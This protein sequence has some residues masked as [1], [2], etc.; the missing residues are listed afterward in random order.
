MFTCLENN[1]QGKT[2]RMIVWLLLAIAFFIP[3][4]PWVGTILVGILALMIVVQSVREKKWAL[5][6]S[7]VGGWIWGLVICSALSITVSPIPFFSAY[8]WLYG[9]ASYV[10]V[11]YATMTYMTA[12]EDRKKLLTVVI[13]SAILVCLYG[14]VQ[15]AHETAMSAAWVDASEFPL[16]KRRLYSTLQNPNLMGAYLLE[17]LSMAGP[18]AICY[19]RLKTPYL[20]WIIAGFFLLC[21]VFTYSRGIWI[22][23]ACMVLYWGLVLNRKLLLSLLA[24][25]AVLFFYHGGVA[26]R[27]WSLFA[28]ADTSVSLRYAIWD[29]TTYMIEEFPLLGIGWGA[30]WQV[31]P[32][33]NYF[34]QDT[35]TII[36]H[37]HNMYLH[38]AAE[39][40]IPGCICFLMVLILHAWKAY[41]LPV[42]DKTTELVIKYGITALVVGVLV[43]G[44][45]DYELFSNQVSIVFWQFLGLG[46]AVI[47]EQSSGKEPVYD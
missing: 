44:M 18:L 11:Y 28:H 14:L 30:Y 41:R 15:F 40:G 16:L 25:P 36:Y 7:P 45:T 9:M 4:L 37:A 26:Q 38:I 6:A 32:S 21:V 3:L 34:I 1:C 29:S 24:I 31:Y 43:S 5:S 35:S 23:L 46:A 42:G 33:Y 13:A 2:K 12:Y 47:Q 20:G 39:I 8:N 10:L 19:K 27:L 17:V 22:S